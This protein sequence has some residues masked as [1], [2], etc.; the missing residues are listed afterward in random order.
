MASSSVAKLGGLVIV[1]QVIP[2]DQASIQ[3]QTPGGGAAEETST[4]VSPSKMEDDVPKANLE[5]AVLL[6]LGVV[7]VV[8]GLLSVL[9]S[10]TAAYPRFLTL[11]VAFC[12]GVL[13]VI[14]GWMAA[15]S[16][17]R[18][19]SARMWACLS[20]N[21]ISVLFSLG[22]MAYLGWVLASGPISEQLCDDPDRD[23][24]C[25]GQLWPLDVLVSGLRGFFL[26]LLILQACVAVAACVLATMGIRQ[27]Y[28]YVP[29]TVPIEEHRC[30]GRKEE[31]PQSP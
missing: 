4:P 6:G 10:L 7:Q 12:G 16:R 13:F 31:E 5:G 22:G 28:R 27:L 19:S 18:V 30:D 24:W 15:L 20:L 26:V 23:N 29:I 8:I 3:L 25:V 11:H 1:T 17:R 2:Q 9:F 14:S 21:A